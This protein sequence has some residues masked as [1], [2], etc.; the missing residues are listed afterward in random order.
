MPL[1][2][3]LPLVVTGA[4][5][6]VGQNLIAE[7][8]AQGYRNIIALDKHKGNL[9]ILQKLHPNVQCIQA[10]LAV[11]GSRPGSWEDH[12]AGAARLFLLQARITGSQEEQFRHDTLDS[13]AN[14]LRAASKHNIPF[15]VFSGS[16]VVNSVADDLY[17]RSK[18]EQER[19]VLDSGLPCCMVRPTLMF[20]WFD[21]KHLGWLSRFM[22]KTPVFPIPGHGRYVRQPLYARDFCR[23]LIRCAE[24]EPRGQSFDL[25][26]QERI[27]YVDIIRTIKNLKKLHTLILHLPVPLFRFLMRAYGLVFPNPPFVAEQLDALMAEDIFTGIDMEE[28]F[29]VKPTDFHAAMQETFCHPE[30]SQIVLERWQ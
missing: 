30:Y 10:D 11:P 22:A 4:A 29:G 15:T 24:T 21:P 2:K 12:F 19:M 17:T 25:T 16:S 18:K 13:T 23:V 3:H 9:D 1:D 14:V 26:G 7:L 5:G 20:G 8:D 28:V 27:T 6:L